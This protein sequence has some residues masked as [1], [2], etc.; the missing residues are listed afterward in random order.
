MNAFRSVAAV[1]GVVLLS[2]AESACAQDK[3]LVAGDPPLTQKT[4]DLYQQ[5]WEWYCDVQLTPEQRRQHTQHFIAFWK[6]SGPA[7]TKPLLARYGATEKEWRS[8]LE[9][10]GADQER[11]RIE[12][13]ENWMTNLRKSTSTDDGF[14]VSVYDDAYKPGGTNNPILAAGEP[15]LTQA[16][17]DLNTA[18]IELILDIRLTNEQRRKFRELWIQD[19]KSWDPSMRREQANAVET[20]TRLPTY[21][22]YTRH[23][24]RSF[25][26]PLV[27]A[28]WGKGTASYRCRWLVSLHESAYKPG[29]ERNP[30]LVEAM[31]PLT[32]VVADRYGDY[33]EVMFDLSIS[34]G[35][36]ASQRQVLQDYLIKDW[37]KMNADDRN[38]LLADLKRWS[39]AAA[40]GAAELNECRSALGPKLMA[41]LHSAPTDPRSLYLLGVFDRNRALYQEKLEQLKRLERLIASQSGSSEDRLYQE[42]LDKERYEDRM[43]RE[44]LDQKRYEDRMYQERLDRQRY[45]DR[46]YQERLDRQRRR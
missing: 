30:V 13:R 41:Q 8:C 43:Y 15:P 21:N 38:E 12:V 34:G 16:M 3:V 18:T 5:M 40:G 22:N 6:K 2:W 33:V 35:L 39:D 10:K 36:T 28:E 4:V 31:P 19:W 37:K 26:Q 44:R 9:L 1:A 46:M 23:L 27:L 17:V 20:W 29:S 14:L 32:Q 7:V 42:R 24:K 25:F 11:K 45:E